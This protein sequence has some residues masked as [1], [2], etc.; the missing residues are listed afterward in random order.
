MISDNYSLN[1][2]WVTPVKGRSKWK[3]NVIEKKEK[4]KELKETT[5]GF[6]LRDNVITHCHDRLN[7]QIQQRRQQQSMKEYT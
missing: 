4:K 2:A 6:S 1:T 5:T 7:Q 3:N